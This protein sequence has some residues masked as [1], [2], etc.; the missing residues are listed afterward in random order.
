MLPIKTILE[1]HGVESARLIRM[2]RRSIGVAEAVAGDEGLSIP[3]P[4]ESILTRLA[5]D[6]E[7]VNLV[8]RRGDPQDFLGEDARRSLQSSLRLRTAW[9]LVLFR[10]TVSLAE[11]L[12]RLGV[13]VLF[14]K[15]LVLC[16]LLYGDLTSRPT[17]DVDILVRSDDFLRLRKELLRMGFSEDFHF[18]VR[19]SKYYM[20]V[21]REA[22]FSRMLPDGHAL[23][24]EVQWAPVLPFYSVPYDNAPFFRSAATAQWGDAR[25][26]VP[27]VEDQFLLLLAHHG[28]S[29]LWHSLKHL[30]DLASFM[31]ERG[32]GMDW[33]RVSRRI[34]EWGMQRNA[35]VGFALCRELLGSEIPSV[36]PVCGDAG[37]LFKMRRRLLA[38][39]PPSRVQILPS[40]MLL[41]LQLTEGLAAKGRLL[42]G[43]LRKWV[44][45]GLRDLEHLRL[46]PLL[47]PLY[48]LLKP[49][50]F[51]YIPRP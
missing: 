5:I 48:Y 3:S 33:G 28:V 19:H 18:P 31:R 7:V 42:G 27:S 2:L 47:F 32:G 11:H 44:S 8:F 46:P 39:G 36:L 25:I 41:Q 20:G 30:A 24:V 38:D 23:N 12:S 6:H 22:A 37:L 4:D 50:R 14:Y 10:E 29:E 35:G 26:P 17:R 43:Y 13:E 51:L 15:G 1:D 40:N 49:F 34:A 16:D 45:P 21:N 9:N